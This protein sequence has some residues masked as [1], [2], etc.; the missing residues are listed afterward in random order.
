MKF[1]NPLNGELWITQ[2][3][4]TNSSNRAIDISAV[5]DRPVCAIADGKITT[6]TPTG[7]SY[8]VQSVDDSDIR[9]F[10]VHT[11]KWLPVGTAVKKGQVICYIAPKSLNGNFPTHLHCGTDLNHNLMDYMDR[12]IVF[13]TGYSDIRADWFNGADLNWNLFQDLQYGI[14]TPPNAPELQKLQEQ[15]NTLQGKLDELAG[16]LVGLQGQL[17]A[18]VEE[19]A[20]EKELNQENSTELSELQKRYDIL[21]VEKNRIE[22]ERDE[23]VKEL[24]EYKGG[25]FVWLVDFLEN[26]FPKK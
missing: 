19:L 12:S 23:A 1:S 25:R 7:N 18:K 5:Q 22:N 14:I 6:A 8:C 20:K 24:S 10:Y 17:K 4:H 11:Y 3:Y 2:N 15:V 21:N 26:L 9:I 16:Q 13:R